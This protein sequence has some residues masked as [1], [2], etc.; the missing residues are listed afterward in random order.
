ML[1]L[2]LLLGTNTF[3]TSDA[4]VVRR[5]RRGT[6]DPTWLAVL[7]VPPYHRSASQNGHGWKLGA[8]VLPCQVL[9]LFLLSLLHHPLCT[10]LACT[11]CLKLCTPLSSFSPRLGT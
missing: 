6:T 7:V 8:C 3:C 10:S 4:L 2:R 9:H 1:G 11:L 5:L